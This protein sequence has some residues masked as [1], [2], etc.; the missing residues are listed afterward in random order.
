[1]ILDVIAW[2]LLVAGAFL[3]FAAGLGLLRF[4]DLLSRIHTAAKPQVLGLTLL[5]IGLALRLREGRYLWMLLLVVA[6][7]MLTAPV[8]AH[9]VARAGYRTGKVDREALVV[10]ELTRDLVIAKREGD[11]RAAEERARAEAAIRSERS[12]SPAA[13][14]RGEDRAD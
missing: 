3:T 8:S 5:M 2:T 4:P 11:R 10:D 13:H 1:M 12:G 14:P 9:L 6:F 7:Q